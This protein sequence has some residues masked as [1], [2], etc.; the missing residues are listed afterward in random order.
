MR[1]LRPPRGCPLRATGQ[2]TGRRRTERALMRKVNTATLPAVRPVTTRTLRRRLKS[3]I[4]SS[5]MIVGH[6]SAGHRLGA[7]SHERPRSS[8]TDPE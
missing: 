1:D 4:P 8:A 5:A 3:A 2:H 7:V 6:D